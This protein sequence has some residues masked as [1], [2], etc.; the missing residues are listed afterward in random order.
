M[1]RRQIIKIDIC[2]A[3][4]VAAPQHQTHIQHPGK[5]PQLRIDSMHIYLQFI[6]EF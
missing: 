4:H 6:L 2:K 5:A 3:V 1:D